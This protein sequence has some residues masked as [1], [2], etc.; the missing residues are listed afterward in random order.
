MAYF[1]VCSQ[2]SSQW[3]RW[4]CWALLQQR[5]HYSVTWS[6]CRKLLAQ[7]TH[8][9]LLIHVSCDHMCFIFYASAPHS[10][11]L[12]VST[13]HQYSRTIFI[14]FFIIFSL[15]TGHQSVVLTVFHCEV[16]SLLSVEGEGHRESGSCGSPV[17]VAKRVP[18]A[19]PTYSCW[20][21]RIP[22]PQQG[23]LCWLRP[24]MAALVR[25]FTYF[26][27]HSLSPAGS[28]D[29]VIWS[30]VCCPTFLQMLAN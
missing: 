4:F 9:W 24:W 1:S 30:C 7:K 17:M 16:V 13:R 8:V 21:R 19:R 26:P 28:V 20:S 15:I 18:A 2:F 22:F 12:N 3:Q 29:V 23:V 27:Q 5:R 6:G 14:L 10:F 25:G 11:L